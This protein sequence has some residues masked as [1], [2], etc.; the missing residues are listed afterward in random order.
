M[1]R[2]LFLRIN[3][4]SYDTYVS[5]ILAVP[6]HGGRWWSGRGF[7]GARAL[8]FSVAGAPVLRCLASWI[9]LPG[10]PESVST[11]FGICIR[12]RPP[13]FQIMLISPGET[14][15]RA[16]KVSKICS[17]HAP[18]LV[19]KSSRFGH[20]IFQILI[21][22]R[23]RSATQISQILV[24]RSGRPPDLREGVSP[25]QINLKQKLPPVLVWH[26]IIT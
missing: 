24:R 6:F 9:C 17:R 7:Q 10:F 11:R 23:A 8:D 25:M 21:G 13:V 4:A 2:V 5:K 3:T 20:E 12:G 16:P 22:R 26:R 19:T 15:F 18:D 1:Y 14:R